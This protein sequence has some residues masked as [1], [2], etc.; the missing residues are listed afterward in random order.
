MS[1]DIELA[2]P[3]NKVGQ[4]TAYRR[5]RPSVLRK[6]PRSTLIALARRVEGL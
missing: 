5:P 2:F 1:D 6:S 3:R 4:I